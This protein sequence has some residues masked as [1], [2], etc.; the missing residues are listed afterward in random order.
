MKLLA[1]AVALGGIALS[2]SAFAAVGHRP[3]PT[4]VHSSALLFDGQIRCSVSI[5]TPAHVGQPLRVRVRLHNVSK[6][7]IQITQYGHDTWLVING[8]DG[9]TFDTR[10]S[11]GYGHG[12]PKLHPRTIAAG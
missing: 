8:S 6:Q 1:G 5:E 7:P 2:A 12:G 3:A 11:V 10:M 9:R 4:T